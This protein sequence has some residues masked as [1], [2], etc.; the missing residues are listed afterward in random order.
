M[1]HAI[2]SLRGSTRM[3]SV[4]YHWCYVYHVLVHDATV[5]VS[6]QL[7]RNMSERTRDVLGRT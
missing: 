6:F 7:V 3:E 4:S 1:A 2:P 5:I